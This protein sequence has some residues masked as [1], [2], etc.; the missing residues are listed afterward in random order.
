MSSSSSTPS[1][2]TPAPFKVGD[3]V[4][5][6]L[7]AAEIKH[8]QLIKPAVVRPAKVVQAWGMTCANLVVFCDGSNDPKTA[9]QT[10]PVRWLTSVSHSDRG[11]E[12]Y[13][14]YKPGN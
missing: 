14:F 1:T 4:L 10:G 8:G 11:V 7:Q 9:E 5:Y 12:A 3:D 13:T 6:V 2:L